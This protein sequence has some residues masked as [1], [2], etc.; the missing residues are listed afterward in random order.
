MKI[1]IDTKQR[2][3]T[4]TYMMM[5]IYKILMGTFLVIFVP[6]KCDNRICGATDN[7]FNGSTINSIGNISNL[8]LLVL[9]EHYILLK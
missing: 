4:W 2:I 9:L 5:E 1:D 8:L 3:M 6:Q 7:F